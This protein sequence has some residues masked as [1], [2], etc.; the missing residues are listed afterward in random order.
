[1]QRRAAGIYVAVFLVIAAGAYTYIGVAEEPT[2]EVNDPDYTLQE[3]GQKFTVDD[4]QYNVTSVGDGSATVAWTNESARFTAALENNTTIQRQ[5]TT[6]RVLVGNASDPSQATLR[7]VQNLSENTPTVTQDGQTYVVVGGNQTANRT[8]VPV[9][10]YK[11][12]QFGEPETRTIS[13]GNQF[14]YE[15]NATTIGNITA[16]EV[17]L[18][19]TGEQTTS[20]SF[21]DGATG[22]LGPNDK[23]FI[24]HAA[25]GN[26]L[27]SADIEGYNAQQQ[28]I[29]HFNERIAGLWGVAILSALAAILL[30]MLALMPVKD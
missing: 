28:E 6:F 9:D 17:P 30:I 27:L 8:L 16:E 12:Q 18:Q 14:Q 1:M 4:R 23:E 7:E 10:E 22:Q 19:W 11:Q 25:N 2:I 3:T 24:A 26:L 29:A 21:D 5:N 15:G 20:V 13:E